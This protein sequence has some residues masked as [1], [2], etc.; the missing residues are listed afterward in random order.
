MLPFLW[1]EK[2]N[3]CSYILRFRCWIEN[4]LDCSQVLYMEFLLVWEVLHIFLLSKIAFPNLE[5]LEVVF[6]KQLD[7]LKLEKADLKWSRSLGWIFK[8]PYWKIIVILYVHMRSIF[9]FLNSFWIAF[10]EQSF[11]SYNMGFSPVF[12]RKSK[13]VDVILSL[14]I[15]F[16][17]YFVTLWIEVQTQCKVLGLFCWCFITGQSKRYAV[18]CPLISATLLIGLYKLLERGSIFLGLFLK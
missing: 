7:N 14:L 4:F 17:V 16:S 9:F 11:N 5:I 3:N 8:S 2:S 15:L 1:G 10:S 12:P 18:L 6:S 13:I